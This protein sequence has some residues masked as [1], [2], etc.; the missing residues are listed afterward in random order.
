MEWVET[1]AKTLEEAKELALDQL[2]VDEADAEFEVLEEPKQGLFGR[3][4]SEAR[5]R[6]RVR[7][8]APRAKQERRGKKRS[9][10]GD[11]SDA[12]ASATAGD[13]DTSAESAVVAAEVAAAST[14]RSAGRGSSSRQGSSRSGGRSD[15]RSERSSSAGG[16][17]PRRDSSRDRDQDAERPERAPVAIEDV[18]AEARRFLEGLLG[19]FELEGDVAIER[20]GDDL[21]ADVTGDDLGV[22]IGPRGSTLLAIQDV[23]RV[24]S[25]R[26][27]GDHDSH[28]RIDIGGYRERRRVALTRFTQDQ[29]AEVLT[30]GTAR[31][32]EPMASADRK[33][34]HDTVGAID[35][36]S[37]RSE[38]EDPFRRVVITPDVP[39]DA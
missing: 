21:S 37:S 31:V 30:S 16:D 4:R 29:A 32:L 27:L 20:D 39:A 5:V 9:E 25:Q 18:E 14:S 36:V 13:G 22:L 1:T 28:L 33:I 34:V 6:A 2:G 24:A 17:R 10:R 35:G 8:T 38:G 7:P 3:L 23:A 26:R 15:G 19:A 12:K 11:G